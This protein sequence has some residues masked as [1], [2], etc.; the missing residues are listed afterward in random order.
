MHSVMTTEAALRGQL[1]GPAK[2][3]QALK[4]VFEHARKVDA[5]ALPTLGLLSDG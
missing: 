4:A 3:I 1:Y 2:E 5:S